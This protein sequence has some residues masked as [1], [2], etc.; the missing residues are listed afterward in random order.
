MKKVV[1]K[2]LVG[3][4]VF[5]AFLVGGFCVLLS[6]EGN[7]TDPTKVFYQWSGWIAYGA[8]LAGLVLPWGKWWGIF[9][10]LVGLLHLSVFVFFDFYFEWGLM[11]AELTKKPYTYAGIGALGLM[12]VLGIFSLGK[13][14][15]ILRFGVW[16]AV[17]CSLL[18]IVMI[19][20]VLS[21]QVWMVILVSVGVLGVKIFGSPKKLLVKNDKK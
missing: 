6:L 18:H 16:G 10:L 7:F 9:A 19:Q 15:P 2:K 3:L 17:V 20:K 12:G 11:I 1:L 21:W 4:S 13:F 8:L 14:Y 5:L